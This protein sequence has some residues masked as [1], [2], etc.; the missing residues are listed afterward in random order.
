MAWFTFIRHAEAEGNYYRRAHGHYDSLLTPNGEAQV[1]ALRDRFSQTLFDEVYTSDLYRTR[2]T[3]TALRTVDGKPANLS[4]LL[5]EIHLGDWEDLPWGGLALRDKDI[6]TVFTHQPGFFPGRGP[7][8]ESMAD[9]SSRM[10]N[11]IRGLAQAHPGRHLAVVSHGVAIRALIAALRGIPLGRLAEVPHTDNTSVSQ[12]EWD[13][14]SAPCVMFHGDN[15]HLGELSTLN[16]Q[17]WWR[18]D[19]RFTDINLWYKPVHWNQD[20]QLALVYLR[21]AWIAVYGSP[22]GFSEEVA[23]SQTERMA[24]AHPDAVVFAMRNQEPVGLVV[25]DTSIRTDHNAGHISLVYLVPAVR[26]QRLGAQL[27]GH[28]TSFYRAR[29]RSFLQLRVAETNR[30]AQRLY[31]SL[32]FEETGRENGQFCKLYIM[33]KNIMVPEK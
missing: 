6:Y 8:G 4:P 18:K 16:Q 32:G 23:D 25:L 31:T 20:K 5:R 10:V 13:G 24:A 15:S 29:G 33:R 27:V 7:D 12:A 26:G 19:S 11:A 28:A 3:A 17:N 30:P 2:R 1:R 22:E 14:I 21:D 9:V